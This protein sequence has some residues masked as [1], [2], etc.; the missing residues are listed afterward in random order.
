ML[1]PAFILDIFIK[2]TFAID[3]ILYIAIM[4]FWNP[5]KARNCKNDYDYKTIASGSKFY[6]SKKVIN[7]YFKD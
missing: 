1:V 5:K 3:Y 4:S 2:V 7:F 6:F